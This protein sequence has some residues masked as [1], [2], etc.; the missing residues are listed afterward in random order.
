MSYLIY[1]PVTGSDTETQVIHFVHLFGL[2]LD[3]KTAK[4]YQRKAEKLEKMLKAAGI[5][6]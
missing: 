4:A 2:G 3:L 6:E 1:Y 5:S